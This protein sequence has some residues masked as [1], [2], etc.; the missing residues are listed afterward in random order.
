MNRPSHLNFFLTDSE[1]QETTDKELEA[2]QNSI[3]YRKQ[4]NAVIKGESSLPPTKWVFLL[5]TGLTMLVCRPDAAGSGFTELRVGDSDTNPKER[6]A[7]VNLL[8]WLHRL[9]PQRRRNVSSVSSLLQR[10]DPNAEFYGCD[11]M[12]WSRIGEAEYPADIRHLNQKIAEAGQESKL[13]KTVRPGSKRKDTDIAAEAAAVTKCRGALDGFGKDRLRSDDAYKGI[14]FCAIAAPCQTATPVRVLP[15]LGTE[16]VDQWRPVSDKTV[17]G[18]R[19]REFERSQGYKLSSYY[20][21]RVDLT[22]Q[23]RGYEV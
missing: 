7:Q 5:C 8:R 21:F 16:R 14:A 13:R 10:A 12:V 4:F 20:Q 17:A 3:N 11:R 1:V 18:R 15:V 6:T 19:F 22:A 2:R 23:P 9:R